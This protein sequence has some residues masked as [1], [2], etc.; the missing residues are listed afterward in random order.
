MY[1]KISTLKGIYFILKGLLLFSRNDFN[2]K[3]HVN[4]EICDVAKPDN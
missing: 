3:L 1:V 4:K 2:F